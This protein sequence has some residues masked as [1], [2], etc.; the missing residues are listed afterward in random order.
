MYV[1]TQYVFDRFY[2][3]VLA[4]AQSEKVTFCLVLLLKKM[5]NF[6]LTSALSHTGFYI[7]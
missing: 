1:K 4:E 5:V 6:A 2:I 7:L 3:F